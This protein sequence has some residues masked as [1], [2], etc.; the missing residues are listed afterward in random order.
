MVAGS[1]WPPAWRKEQE[2]ESSHLEL[3]AQSNGES[4]LA[5][6]R[7]SNLSKT[8]FGDCPQQAGLPELPQ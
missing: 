8:T 5:M 3:Q 2:A 4:E 1:R 6:V 7:I